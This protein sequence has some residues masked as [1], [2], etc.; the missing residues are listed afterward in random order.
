MDG[1]TA[2]SM[3][4]TGNNDYV[5]GRAGEISRY[6]ILKREWHSV[7]NSRAYTHPPTA[8]AVARTLMTQRIQRFEEKFH[9]TPTAFEVY[10]LWNAP[11]QALNGRATRTV[12][13]RARRFANLCDPQWPATGFLQAFLAPG[14]RASQHG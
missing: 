14:Y 5:V 8:A 3:V 11:A 9:R 7:T 13:A 6:Q 1:W 4:E 2:L 12:A 10:V